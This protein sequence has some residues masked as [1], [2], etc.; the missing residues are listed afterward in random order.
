MHTKKLLFYFLTFAGLLA[1]LPARAQLT[2]PVNTNDGIQAQVNAYFADAPAMI[3]IAGCESGYRQ[4]NSSG[5]P[6]LGG[7]SGNYIGVFQISM[8][9]VPEALA[10]GWDVYT[11]EG[12]LAYAKYLYQKQGTWPWSGCVNAPAAT[13]PASI[14]PVAAASSSPLSIAVF[15]G[16][17]TLNLK[18]GMNDPEVAVLQHLLNAEGFTVATSGPGSPGNETTMFGAL[19]RQAVQRFQCQKNITCSGNESTTGYGRVG[20]ITRAA[21][22]AKTSS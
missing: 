10:M 12:N 5:L 13:A 7:T 18:T 14:E 20:P 17:L 4:F 11:T 22:L 15:V 19:T 6:L 3:A 1:C 21:L 8:G 9:H 2:M 16:T